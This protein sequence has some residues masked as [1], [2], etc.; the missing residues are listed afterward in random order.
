MDM[1]KISHDDQQALRCAMNYWTTCWDW[2]CPTLFGI[3]LDELKRILERWPL[4][5]KE[6]EASAAAA[7]LSALR[8]LLYGASAQPKTAIEELI[9]ISYDSADLLCTKLANSHPGRNG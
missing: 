5:A 8:E 3:E 4:I 9:G 6:D 1:S 2:E 7:T